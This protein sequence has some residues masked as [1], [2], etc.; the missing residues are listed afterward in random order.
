[1]MRLDYSR[2]SA[3][4]YAIEHA[5]QVITIM[6]IMRSISFYYLNEK[7]KN[8]K[9]GRR[10]ETRIQREQRMNSELYNQM[11][12][13]IPQEDIKRYK[14]AGE[15]MYNIDF[16]T[17]TDD[18]ITTSVAYVVEGLKSGIHPSFLTKDEQELMEKTYGKEWFKKYGFD[19][20]EL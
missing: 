10:R 4:N 18:H 12:G 17:Y 2:H 13:S 15:Q 20:L 5:K 3:T 6:I 1:M 11:M 14:K 7:Y 8:N 9:M 19:S 16:T